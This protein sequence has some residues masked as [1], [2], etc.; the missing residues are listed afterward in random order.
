MVANAEEKTTRE[1]RIRIPT[2]LKDI[3]LEQVQKVLL[4][5]QNEDIEPFAKRVH[6]L[7]VMTDRTPQ[8]ISTVFLDDLNNIYD[9]LFGMIQG[10]G[11]V[12]LVQKVKYLG[13]EYGFIEDVRDMETGAF[14]DIDQMTK[15]DK[16]AGNLHKIMAVLYRPIDAELRGNYRLKSYVK[17]HPKE[18]EER[19]AIF[20]KHMTFDVVRGAADFF[21]L[22]TQKCLNILDG[23]FPH[24]PEMTVERVMRGAGITSFTQWRDELLQGSTGY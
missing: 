3:T 9:R 18:R 10:V 4:I 11:R 16:Y 19:A 23:S 2:E 21:L 15:G 20:L 17:E 12:P 6:A 1:M 13:R 14:I 24:L 22:V 5:D 8:E 7:A